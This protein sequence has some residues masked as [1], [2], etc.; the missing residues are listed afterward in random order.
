MTVAVIILTGL[1]QEIIPQLL[2]IQ[3]VRE[4]T[5]GC[6]K[7]GTDVGQQ[8]ADCDTDHQKR[9]ILLL[10]TKIKQDARDG[11]HHKV[12]PSVRIAEEACKT[13]FGYQFSKGF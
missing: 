9:L 10:D 7:D 1:V 12:S 13:G 6:H 8:A 3:R 4:R 5:V 2:M 11:D